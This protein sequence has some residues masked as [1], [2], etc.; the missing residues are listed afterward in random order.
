MI[1]RLKEYRNLQLF[2][3]LLSFFFVLPFLNSSKLSG[4]V[5]TLFLSLVLV[6]AVLAA[7][8]GKRVFRITLILGGIALLS[9]WWDSPYTRTEVSMVVSKISFCLFFAF[10]AGILL[11]KIFHTQKVTANTIYGATCVYILMGICWA[12]IYTLIEF[13][14]PNAFNPSEISTTISGKTHTLFI[15]FFYYSFV[16]ITTLGYG[17]IVPVAKFA[18]MLSIL[19][20]LIGQLFIVILVSRLVGMYTAQQEQ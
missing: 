19:E 2:I 13:L 3:T 9:G 11:N 20:S 17:D 10:V 16:T 4:L 18:K 5:L 1:K 15:D 12:F 14:N 8:S 7:G 6:F